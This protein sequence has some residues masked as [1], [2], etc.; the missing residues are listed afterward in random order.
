VPQEAPDIGEFV[1]EAEP[2]RGRLV[3]IATVLTTLA[4]AATGYLQ[5]TALRDHADA[6]VQAERLAALAVNV[7]AGNKD[8]AQV[9][10]DRYRTLRTEQEQSSQT[11]GSEASRWR[12]IAAAT[13]RDTRAIAGTQRIAIRC[14]PDTGECGGQPLP[15]ICSLRFDGQWCPNGG[16]YGP[17]SDD[18][19]PAR[20]EQAAQWESYRLL[21]MREAANEQ[22]E[23]AE[24]RFAHLAAALTMLS[25]G[26]FLFGYSLTPQGRDRRGLFTLVATGFT[27]FGA[28][29]AI[30]HGFGRNEHPPASAATSFA[31]AEVAL[32]DGDYRLAI[33]H[34]RRATARWPKAV[35]AH[36]DLAQAEFQQNEPAD[37]GVSRPPKQSSLTAAID[38][39]SRAI[40]NGSDSPTVTF[41]KASNLLFLGLLTHDDH[42]VQEARDL[43]EE[44]AMRF[45]EQQ[46][47]GR[48]P[49]ALLISARF[50]V[51]EADLALGARSADVEYC[52]AIEEMLAL[53]R[54]VDPSVIAAASDTDLKL[55]AA[56]HPKFKAKAQA[57]QEHVALAAVTLASGC[58]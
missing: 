32:H 24:V 44:T 29:W 46:K 43:S 14:S 10:I 45:E 3:A 27:L 7:S 34:F 23:G 11:A 2:R 39:D 28:G 40:D 26:V 51:A 8:Q 20:Y 19:F 36:A 18:G 49:G 47:E 38:D 1:G 37:T 17:E 30:H 58:P 5:A 12:R 57:T 21:A 54:E 41:D 31:D 50:S 56:A 48:H 55:I 42:R 35:E 13:A 9:Q 4:A 33:A 25:V 15:V 16:W 6:A 22:S 53:R 52:R